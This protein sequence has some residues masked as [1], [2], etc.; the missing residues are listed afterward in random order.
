MVWRRKTKLTTLAG[1]FW[2][3][4]GPAVMAQSDTADSN[5]SCNASFHLTCIDTTVVSDSF[6]APAP[7]LG[8]GWLEVALIISL[9]AAWAWFHTRRRKRCFRD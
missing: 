6:A 9:A 1:L 2:I 8:G 4:A 5:A 3:L 7:T